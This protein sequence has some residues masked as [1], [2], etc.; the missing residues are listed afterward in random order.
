MES[1]LTSGRNTNGMPDMWAAPHAFRSRGLDRL[2]QY[3]IKSNR[4]T[5]AL[6]QSS[7]CDLHDV[8]VEPIFFVRL[9]FQ[10]FQNHDM[11]ETA[12]RGWKC[13]DTH[14]E[15]CR[16]FCCCRMAESLKLHINLCPSHPPSV[17]PCIHPSIYLSYTH[18]VRTMGCTDAQKDRQVFLGF[19]QMNFT[20]IYPA[21]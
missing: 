8:G 3:C 11:H 17:H 15:K 5:L 9:P 18:T 20:H 13:M 14:W 6:A 10:C 12:L 21:S 2:Y 7:H 1:W 19:L 4:L 16:I